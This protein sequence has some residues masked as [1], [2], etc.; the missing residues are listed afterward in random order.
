MH[1]ENR[2][3]ERDR[4]LDDTPAEVY[5]CLSAVLASTVTP[6]FWRKGLLPLPQIDLVLDRLRAIGVRR[7]G[8]FGDEPLVRKDCA[9]ITRAAKSRGF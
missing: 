2:D 7:I 8:I 3:R 9:Q 5:P 1:V 6:R 4:W